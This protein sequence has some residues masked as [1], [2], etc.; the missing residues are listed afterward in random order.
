MPPIDQLEFKAEVSLKSEILKSGIEDAEI[1]SDSVV[2]EATPEVFNLKAEGDITSAKLILDKKNEVLKGLKTEETVKSR[3]PIDYLKKMAKASKIADVV[4][5]KW[6]SDYPMKMQFTTQ[7]KASLG[8][9]I[10]PRV[11]ED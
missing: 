10:A 6:S 9:V 8:F 4:S 1:V 5:L 11:Q 2:F 7:D 3:Y